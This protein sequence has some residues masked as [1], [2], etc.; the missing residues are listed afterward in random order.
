MFKKIVKEL[1]PSFWRKISGK[2]DPSRERKIASLIIGIILFLAAWAIPFFIGYEV[3]EMMVDYDANMVFHPFIEDNLYLPIQ[4]T[5][6]QKPLTNV[7]MQIKTCYMDEYEKTPIIPTLSVGEVYPHHLINKDT[8]YALD[9][10]FESEKFVCNPKKDELGFL[11]YIETY[12]VKDRIYVPPQQ[13]KKYECG[14]CDY[15]INL[16]SKEFNKTVT[17]KFPGP[18]E[19]GVYDLDIIPSEILDIEIED[20]LPSSPLV[21]GLFSPYDLCI[22]ENKTTKEKCQELPKEMYYGPPLEFGITP[23][24]NSLENLTFII[25]QTIK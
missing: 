21:V 18:L 2:A 15:E 7:Q 13:C 4:L 19:V 5:N 9:K 10:L 12:L 23:T 24:N 14:F 20:M 17:G 16:I 11:C 6:G 8:V 25:K 22:L 3:K 1:F